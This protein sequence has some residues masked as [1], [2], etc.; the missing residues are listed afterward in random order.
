MSTFEKNAVIDS[1][2]DHWRSCGV[3]NGE[4]LLIHTSL[5]RIIRHFLKQG[6]RLDSNDIL[7]TFL[8]AVGNSGTLL[9][10]TFNISVQ[11]LVKF[12]VR[13]SPSQMGALTELARQRRDSI[14][15]QHPLLSFAVIGKRKNEF[16]D[17]ADYTGIGHSS[18]FARLLHLDGRIG[19]L[20]LPE[21]ESMSFYHHVEYMLDADHRHE[22]KFEAEV[23]QNNNS[24]VKRSHA[25]Y[26]RRRDD[27]IVTNVEPMG[28]SLWD[29]GFY[30][31]ERFDEGLGFR[32]VRAIDVFRETAKVVVSGNARGMLYDYE[33]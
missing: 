28:N 10:P 25:F 4:T 8:N 7:Q 21:N 32:S 2:T 6:V 17:L 24:T 27:G 5:R 22:V 12:D 18:P 13:K 16:A 29:K 26:A 14:R 23:T 3:S 9:L 1:L 11:P 15:T 30:S 19:V 33:F 31:G 20:G